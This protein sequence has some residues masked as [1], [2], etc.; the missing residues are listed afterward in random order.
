MGSRADLGYFGDDG[1]YLP[2]LVFEPRI[3]Q[4]LAY[5]LY[6]SFA[7]SITTQNLAF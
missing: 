5:S 3:V 1:N 4:P 2:P 7:T 6:R